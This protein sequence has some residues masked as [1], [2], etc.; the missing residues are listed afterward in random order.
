M[1]YFLASRG[2]S[3]VDLLAV[4][5]DLARVRLVRAGE[6][7]D[8]GGL[9]GPVAADEA[10]DL[11]RVE[12]DGDAVDRVHAA[13]G[14]ADVAHLD[15]RAGL[16]RRRSFRPPPDDRVEGDG[17]RPGRCRRRC[18]GS[19]P[20]RP[21]S[22]MPDCSDCIT[23][24]PSTAPVIVP[25]PPAREVPPMTAAAITYSSI[26]VPRPL[27][28]A[29]RRA[30]CTAAARPDQDAHQG[31]GLDDRALVLMPPSSAASGLPPMANT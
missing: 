4:D 20:R 27:T 8:Q 26:P 3:I 15:E 28:A 16:L 25:T 30:I 17:Q 5:E 23:R 12:V 14:D 21:S 6:G 10:D 2:V 7:L 19:A 31:E 24:A 22:T 9:A 18:P 11:A 1:A 13:E 29:L